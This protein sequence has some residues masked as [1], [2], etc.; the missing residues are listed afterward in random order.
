MT[1]IFT[2]YVCPACDAIATEVSASSHYCKERCGMWVETKVIEYEAFERL[3]RD[4]HRLVFVR[5]AV[6]DKAMRPKYGETR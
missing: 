2:V 4:Y 3:E 5:E 1:R 6:I